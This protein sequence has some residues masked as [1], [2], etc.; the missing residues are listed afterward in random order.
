MPLLCYNI[1]KLYTVDTIVIS[2]VTVDCCVRRM[3]R[4]VYL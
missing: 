2:R 3:A 1:V 4:K